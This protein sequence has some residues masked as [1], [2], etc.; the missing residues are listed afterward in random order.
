MLVR[1]GQSAPYVSGQPFD[2]VD[3]HGDPHLTDLGQHQARLV[4]NRLANEPINAIYTSNLTRTIQ[5]AAPLAS[6]LAIEPTVEAGFREVFLG[7]YEGGAFR[8][9]AADGHPHVMRFRKER[10]WGFIPGAE[11]NA[12]LR[13]RTM[14]AFDTVVERHQ[15]GMVVIFCHGG[16]I[17]A[18][19]GAVVGGEPFTFTGS[20]HTAVSYVV[21]GPSGRLLRLF[22]D[23][24]HMGL[25][26]SDHTL[27][28]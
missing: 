20:R 1:H 26:S 28:A 16:V 23:G 17:G 13:E 19:L 12:D 14:A 22:N 15:G 10:D 7:D 27:D 3:G 18:V 11:S 9:L 5:T 8:E 6:K 2:L 24:S 25:I 4:G 21:T